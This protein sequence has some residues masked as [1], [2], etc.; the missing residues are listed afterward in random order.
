MSSVQVSSYKLTRLVRHVQ[1]ETHTQ[2]E[3]ERERER[4][5][6]MSVVADENGRVTASSVTS[7]GNRYIIIDL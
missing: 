4:R 2:R 1:R 6:V 3:R 7:T 5:V